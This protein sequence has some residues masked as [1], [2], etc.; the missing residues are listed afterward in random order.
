LLVI[1]ENAGA[2]VVAAPTLVT[3]PF[4]SIVNG[5]IVVAL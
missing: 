5:V 3:L 1:L 4:A 2:I